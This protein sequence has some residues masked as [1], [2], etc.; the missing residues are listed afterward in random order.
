MW[1]RDVSC[2]EMMMTMTMQIGLCCEETNERGRTRM[3]ETAAGFIPR[4]W[5][6]D[7]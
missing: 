3:E 7:V 2:D 1:S 4:D 6:N 5:V